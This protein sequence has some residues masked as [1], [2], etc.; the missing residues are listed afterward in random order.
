MRVSRHSISSAALARGAGR[1]ERSARRRARALQWRVGNTTSTR[2]CLDTTREVIAVLRNVLGLKDR[3]DNFVRDT[4]LLGAIP[5]L[6]SMAVA[7]VLASLED[8]FEFM[9][10]DDEIDGATFATLGTLV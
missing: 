1:I 5:E 3:A 4:P 8:R 6:D 2:G 10:A 9:I 7:S